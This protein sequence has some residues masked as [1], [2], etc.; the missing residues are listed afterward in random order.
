[1]LT[2][3]KERRDDAQVAEYGDFR[4]CDAHPLMVGE[5]AEHDAADWRRAHKQHR[6]EAHHPATQLRRRDDLQ[7]AVRCRRQRDAER[8]ERN[9]Y[10]DGCWSTVGG[11]RCA[12]SHGE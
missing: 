8:A 3:V 11:T 5:R 10:R 7:V 9:E 2:E 6:K 1:M 12:N 4:R